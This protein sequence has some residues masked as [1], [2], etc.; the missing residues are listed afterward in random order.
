MIGTPRH[1]ESAESVETLIS[2]FFCYWKNLMFRYLCDTKQSICGLVCGFVL[3]ASFK[4]LWRDTFFFQQK[5]HST[6]IHIQKCLVGQEI[7]LLLIV[8]WCCFEISRPRRDPLLRLSLDFDCSWV[9]LS[10][11]YWPTLFLMLLVSDFF[12]CLRLFRDGELIDQ[13]YDYCWY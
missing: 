10:H 12:Y 7:T 11:F 8:M 5:K 6:S 2:S 4:G 9:T 1:N 13:R 3:V